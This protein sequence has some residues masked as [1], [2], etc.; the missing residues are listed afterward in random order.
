MRFRHVAGRGYCLFERMVNER[1]DD[2][3]AGQLK[4]E[5]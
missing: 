4:V 2:G 3:F 1:V 5:L